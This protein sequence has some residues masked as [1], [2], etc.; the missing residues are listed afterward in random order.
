M[1]WLHHVA[2]WILVPQPRIKRVPPALESEVLTTGLP[3]KSHCA[4]FITYFSS[5]CGFSF[6]F[7]ILQGT[8]TPPQT[9]WSSGKVG[10]VLAVSHW[11]RWSWHIGTQNHLGMYQAPSWM[12]S[13][14]GFLPAVSEKRAYTKIMH[15]LQSVKYKTKETGLETTQD[16]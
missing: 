1:F 16:L 7:T 6:V 4:C 8:A 11:N 9:P 12:P 10:V 5:N 15:L 13:E 3:G 14:G 2:C